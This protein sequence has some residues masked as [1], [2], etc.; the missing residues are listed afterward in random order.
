MPNS[1]PPHGRS[2]LLGVDPSLPQ[3]MA[4]SL[5]MIE[6]TM[7][8]M[9]QRT[10]DKLDTIMISVNNI[11]STLNDHGSR[12]TSA[13]HALTALSVLPAKV[14]AIEQTINGSK[15][16]V[17]VS[18]KTLAF[19]VSACVGAISFLGYF[20]LTIGFDTKDAPPSA[21]TVVVG[22]LNAGSPPKP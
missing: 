19:V 3:D 11:N 16:A 18:G 8:G 5:G 7:R 13:E 14:D 6:A 2:S 4:Y 20:G 10:T 17:A 22:S 15:A 12:L 21:S 9:E 1:Q